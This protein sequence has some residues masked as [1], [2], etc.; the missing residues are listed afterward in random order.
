MSF[1]TPNRKEDLGRSWLENSC[2]VFSTSRK[3]HTEFY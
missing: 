2:L 3:P 1:E